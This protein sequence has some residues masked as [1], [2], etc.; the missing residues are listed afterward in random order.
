M[1]FSIA[2]DEYEEAQVYYGT[3]P[4]LKRGTGKHDLLMS[5]IRSGGMTGTEDIRKS[6]NMDEDQFGA[7]VKDINRD[8]KTLS[9]DSQ[10]L[11]KTKQ[12]KI[13]LDRPLG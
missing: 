7:Q 5:L 10:P 3:T 2:S 6:L 12:G 1:L 4:F 13:R 8:F 11:L 9:G